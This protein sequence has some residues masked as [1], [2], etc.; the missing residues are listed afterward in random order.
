MQESQ[1]QVVLAVEAEAAEKLR[2]EQEEKQH[3]DALEQMTVKELR[4]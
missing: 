3:T 2:L 4:R 1:Q